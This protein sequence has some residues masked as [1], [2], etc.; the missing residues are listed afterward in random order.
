[1]N[2]HECSIRECTDTNQVGLGYG[3]TP[4]GESRV[5]VSLGGP[6]INPSLPDGWEEIG[7]I[8]MT[9][10]CAVH[11]YELLRDCRQPNRS[12]LLAKVTAVVRETDRNFE[13]DGGSSRHWT[14]SF[15]ENLEAA[16]LEI[17]K[18]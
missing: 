16:G 13:S 9:E 2:Y 14:R 12:E 10:E 1:M 4:D 3:D 17:V 8:S 6:K 11:L 7:W 5:C 15:L 18:R